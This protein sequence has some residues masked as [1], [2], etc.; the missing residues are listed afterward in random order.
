M[1]ANFTIV[2]LKDFVHEKHTREWAENQ[3]NFVYK[4]WEVTELFGEEKEEWIDSQIN[5]HFYTPPSWGNCQPYK[6]K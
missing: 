5:G 4:T 1:K 2:P 3:L 6:L